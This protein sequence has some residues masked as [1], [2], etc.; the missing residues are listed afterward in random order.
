MAGVKPVGEE[1]ESVPK[2]FVVSHPG[3]VVE[4]IGNALDLLASS[5]VVEIRR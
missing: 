2:L 4:A 1:A 3:K 5:V